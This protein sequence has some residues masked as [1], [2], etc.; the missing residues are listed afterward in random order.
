MSTARKLRE[1]LKRHGIIV[2]PG[3]Y[4][5]FSAILTERAGFECFY[6]SGSS[7]AVSM[8]MPDIGLMTM[9]EAVDQARKITRCINIP[10]IAD[11]DDGYGNPVNVYRAVREFELAGVA[12]V[13]IEDQVAPKR[14]G[15]LPG[16]EVI[17]AQ[18]MVY[19]I[20]AALDA[21]RDP[22]FVIIARTDAAKNMGIDEAVRR[23]RAYEE[24][25]V[26]MLM[27]HGLKS[28]ED[29]RKVA[30]CTKCPTVAINS[31]SFSLPQFP[32]KALAEMGFKMV[33]FVSLLRRAGKAMIDLLEEIKINGSTE[34]Y[35]NDTLTGISI[36]DIA[37]RRKYA[38]MEMK[39]GINASRRL[40]P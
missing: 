34:R 26:D 29:L 12:G 37:G 38:D 33:L 39:Y 28:E 3:G 21:R 36:Q 5:P 19:K 32:V 24:A 2:V 10:L 17:P 7:T 1:L 20:K 4:D 35:W 30:T 13:H 25:G 31:E 16:S 14:S 22:D 15:S 11:M 27:F 8:G 18:E 23:A 40:Q 6:M 9:T